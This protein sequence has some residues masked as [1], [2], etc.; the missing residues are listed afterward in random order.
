MSDFDENVYQA[1]FLSPAATMFAAS[2]RPPDYFARYGL[3]RGETDVAAIEARIQAVQRFWNKL[4]TNPRYTKLL[5]ALLYANEMKVSRLTLTDATARRKYLATLARE[6]GRAKDAVIEAIRASLAVVAGKGFITPVEEQS[7]IRQWVREAP[8]PSIT[9]HDVRDCLAGV[10]VREPPPPPVI[11]VVPEA[12]MREYRENLGV[13]GCADLWAFLG[14]PPRAP[15][16]HV[17]VA[18]EARSKEWAPRPP[19][20]RKTA[21]ERLISMARLWASDDDA[22]LYDNTMQMDRASEDLRPQ[23]ET[24]LADGQVDQQELKRLLERAEALGI[25]DMIARAFITRFVAENGGVIVDAAP[26]A[27]TVSCKACY[28][29]S[30]IGAETCLNTACGRALWTACVRCAHRMPCLDARCR[31]C[32]F[33]Q[34][35]EPQA[36]YLASIARAALDAGCSGTARRLLTDLQSLW[37]RRPDVEALFQEAETR[38][39]ALQAAWREAEA[40]MERLELRAAQAGMRKVLAQDS[41]FAPPGRKPA[42]ERLLEVERHLARIEELIAEAQAAASQGRFDD[43][44]TKLQHLSRQAK[45]VPLPPTPCPP[46]PARD[47]VATFHQDHVA[48][49]WEPTASGGPIEY[50]VVRQEGRA[51]VSPTDGTE[52]GRQRGCGLI[53]RHMR[54]GSTCLYAVFALREGAAAAPAVS[55]SLHVAAE[56][57]GLKLVVG[58][59]EVTGSWEH[60]AGGVVHVRRQLGEPPEPEAGEPV[61]VTFRTF[62]DSGLRNGDTYGY[63]VSVAYTLPDGSVVT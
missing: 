11:P 43:A 18:C 6:E 20:V 3:S 30:P 56:V 9:E 1:R 54:P 25:S 41:E 44:Y 58:D 52:V 53:D 45:D 8:P 5:G 7:L 46:Q 26:A 23:V 21:A 55:P 19:D 61:E 27:D 36:R 22:I 57:G 33:L 2:G 37:G 38:E 47:V 29:P 14:V 40:A 17:K 4:K 10:P 49:V 60:P 35:D 42:D 15:A 12:R 31:S 50:L 24:A 48:I 28:R 63:R 62:F 39:Q 13:L 51:P 34:A 16:T 32:G 59:G